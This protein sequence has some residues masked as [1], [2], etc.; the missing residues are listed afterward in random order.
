[1]HGEAITPVDKSGHPLRPTILGMDTR[2]TAQN[3]WL[4]NR[5]GGE[6]LFQR[7]GMPIHTINTLPK[8]LWIKENEPEIWKN[9]DR[10]LLIEDFLIQKMTGQAIIRQ[11]LASRTQL[12][13]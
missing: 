5:F 4:R 10:F 11:C 13:N 3:D 8:L 1:M 9:A 12:L 2:T 6:A 7:T